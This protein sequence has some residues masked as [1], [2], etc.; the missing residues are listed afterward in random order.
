MTYFIS[1]LSGVVLTVVYNI[2]IA[3][4]DLVIRYLRLGLDADDKKTLDKL[5]KFRVDKIITLVLVTLI[6]VMGILC[7]GYVFK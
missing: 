6:F 4:D 3:V 1:F 5:V 7:G 2:A